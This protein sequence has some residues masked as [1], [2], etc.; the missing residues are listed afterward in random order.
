MFSRQASPCFFFEGG[1]GTLYPKRKCLGLR[2]A[3]CG[4]RVR[5]CGT[6]CV[7]LLLLGGH[8]ERGDRAHAHCRRHRDIN[9]LALGEKLGE[10]VAER[11]VGA[12][13]VWEANVAPRL[14][15]VVHERAV[16]G[17]VAVGVVPAG[18]HEEV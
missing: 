2:S 10:L 7:E 3:G 12:V 17:L 18:V 4:L 14:A 8:L 11:P 13:T 16:D 9:L 6:C 1:T 5:V 15:V